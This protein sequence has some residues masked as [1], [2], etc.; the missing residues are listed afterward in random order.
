MLIVD[1]VTLFVKRGMFDMRNVELR[2]QSAR[3]AAALVF[4]IVVRS[5]AVE[6]CYNS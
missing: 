4:L 3:P 5:N 1:N 6:R 2:S